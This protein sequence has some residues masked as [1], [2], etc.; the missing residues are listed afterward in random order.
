M[1]THDLNECWGEFRAGRRGAIG[2]IFS[3]LRGA[4]F[5]YLFRMCRNIE[6]AEDLL[7][8]TFIAMHAGAATFTVGRRLE[9]WVFAIARNLFLELKRREQRII[10]LD[11]FRRPVDSTMT[12]APAANPSTAVEQKIDLEKALDELSEETREAF[13]LKHIQGLLFEEVAEIQ[14]IPVPTAKSRVLY[15]LAKIRRGMKERGV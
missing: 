4:V 7:Q 6:I 3:G 15:A 10:R 8:E 9:P 11:Q 12:G 14:G 1:D 2:A 5:S 13:L